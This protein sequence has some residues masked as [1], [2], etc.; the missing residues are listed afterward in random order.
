[1]C[2]ILITPLTLLE[3]EPTWKSFSYWLRFYRHRI[4][5]LWPS[6][7]FTIIF[8]TSQI[9]ITYN[10][11]MWPFA[12]QAIQCPKLLHENLLFVNSIFVN[13]C[14]PWTWYVK[15]LSFL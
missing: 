4:I 10:H 15:K 7:L 2:N 11:G 3:V 12:D 8:I 13:R 1:M 6:Y 14:L 5:R 9:S